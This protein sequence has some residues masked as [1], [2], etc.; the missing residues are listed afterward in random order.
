MLLWEVLA[1]AVAFGAGVALVLATL[2]SAIRTFVL[3][4]ASRDPISSAVFRVVQLPFNLITR[5]AGSYATRDGLLGYLA[6][7]ALVVLLPVWL[8]LIF[9]GYVA[10]FWSLGVNSF[11]E[12][13]RDSGSS[14][15]TLGFAPIEGYVRSSVAFS[16]ATIGLLLVALLIAYLPTMY[17]AF[18]RRETSVTLLEVRAGRPPSATEMIER[19]TRIHGLVNLNEL[20]R[21]WEA[22]F[23][24]IEESHTS[25][26]ALVFFRSP[27]PSYSWV[28]AAGTVLDTASLVLAAVEVP[29]DAQAALCIRAGYLALQRIAGYFSLPL[30]PSP[31]PL[32]RTSITRADFDSAC[33][34]LASHGV[35]LKPD[36]EQ[37]WRDFNGWRVNYDSALLGLARLVKAPVAPWTSDRPPIEHAV[38]ERGA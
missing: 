7:I 15:L 1:R 24:D 22:W 16:E 13:F 17:A 35:P 20:W 33:V 10:I 12:A 21:N 30:D 36:L 23:A 9:V 19:Y 5:M 11:Y 27:Q 4:R 25:L 8:M 37:G 31:N 32:A 28:T 34:E 2:L 3:P 14:L 29:Y 38:P 6:P 18:A 26:P